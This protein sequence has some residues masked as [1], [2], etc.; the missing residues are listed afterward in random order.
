MLLELA[1]QVIVAFVPSLDF[2][3]ATVRTVI[4]RRFIAPASEIVSA[5]GIEAR[6]V[7]GAPVLEH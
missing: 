4:E 5:H 2:P 6:V 7:N 3:P 1:N